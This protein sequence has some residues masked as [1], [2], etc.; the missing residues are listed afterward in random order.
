[1]NLSF[2][3]KIG[4]KE[5]IAI[6]LF[7]V[8]LSVFVLYFLVIRPAMDDIINTK[9]QIA[10][11]RKEIEKKYYSSIGAKLLSKKAPEVKEKM[12]AVENVFIKQ[13]NHLAFITALE[14]LGKKYKIDQRPSVDY[15]KA[16][17]KKLYKEIPVRIRTEGV[18]KNQLAYLDALKSFDYYLNINSIKME[19]MSGGSSYV[20]DED[21]GEVVRLEEN[22][23]GD[24][25]VSL[26][27][28]ATSYWER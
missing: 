19:S 10:D 6:T 9:E 21:L 23:E 11:Q 22:L 25:Y 26:F 15:E 18:Y 12:K 24:A 16:E 14:D 1:M 27:I 7:V 4:E 3:Y 20:Y 28:N 13:K 2:S 5:K 8:L 17:K